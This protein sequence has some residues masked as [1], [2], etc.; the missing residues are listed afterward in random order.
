MPFSLSAK[1]LSFASHV[2]PRLL[3]VAKRAAALSTQDFGFTEE[4]SRTIE[5]EKKLV[6]E[7]KSHTLHSHHIIDCEPG[8]ARPGCSGAV[9]AVPYV[10]GKGYV[11]EWPLIYPVAAAFKKASV[12][13][14]TPI[15]W[16]GVW[17]KLMTEYD[18]DDA[19]AMKAADEAYV[20]RRRAAGQKHVF[21]DGPHFEL[22]RN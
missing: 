3:A 21:I 15:T 18:G 13:L 6:A 20:A 1:S 22:G 14:D 7:G 10:T 9:D 11:W 4:Q 12:E 16:G 8:W 5:Y 17:D 2:D 19:A